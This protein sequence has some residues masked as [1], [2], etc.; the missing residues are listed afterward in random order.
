MRNFC[1]LTVQLVLM[2]KWLWIIVLFLL[3]LGA[4]YMLLP[5]GPSSPESA[6]LAYCSG[7]HL[8][9]TPANIPKAVWEERV[10]PEMA[11]RLGYNYK[12]YDPLAQHTPEENQYITN[13]GAY[14]AKPAIDSLA[15]RQIHDYILSLAPDAIPVDSL[16][17]QR[18]A[19][20]A[21]FEPR[22]VSL[23]E[24]GQA[25]VTC[26]QF[27][28]ASRQF[29]IGDAYG[30]VYKWP[31][32]PDSLP[33]FRT[34]VL[35]YTQSKGAVYVTEVGYM[36][37]SEIPLGVMHR[38][39]HGKSDT[40]AQQLHR[41]VYTIV[42][43][44]DGDGTEEILACEFGNLT[45]ELSTFPASGAQA[46]KKN[47]LPVAGAIKAEV[48]DMNGDGARDIVV[49]AAQGREGVYI[50][51]QKGP[52]EFRAE[53]VVSLGPEYGS[54]WFELFDYN[55]DGFLDIALANGDN[56][57]Y[58]NFLKPYHGLRLY[59]ND[60][61]NTFEQK[62]FYPIYG[63]TRVLAEDFDLDGDLDFAVLAFFPDYGNAPEE[64]F[65][66]LENKA[67]GQYLFEP[68]TF[69][70]ALSGRWLVMDKGDFDQD[71]DAD[72]LLGSFLRLSPGSAYKALS[73]RWR[74]EKVSLLLLENTARD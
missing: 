17:H 25:A 3:A 59:I 46:G 40:L 15:W 24:N 47:L 16:R 66:W 39:Y 67:P 58:T 51:Y 54:S 41:P 53:Q 36:N 52:L 8:A 22:A 12:G 74:R 19:G 68:H 44:L 26:I 9:P 48:A 55:G 14:P 28:A 49:L 7:C 32:L 6:F 29:V 61:N 57:D 31:A 11:A 42:A 56:A 50:L 27:E 65:V 30:K 2:K 21:L 34:P 10:L 45:G 13:S 33:A 64:S 63:A 69:P 4:F 35:S 5:K 72:I 60:G 43:D 62:W 73:D 71:G 23:N 18:N 20:P 37:P 38:I 70:A 1:K